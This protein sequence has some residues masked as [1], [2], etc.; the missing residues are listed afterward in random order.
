MALDRYNL[1]IQR[2]KPEQ[3]DKYKKTTPE[4][5]IPC[6]R[7]TKMYLSIGD[8]VTPGGYALASKDWVINA[9]H[10]TEVQG[11]TKGIETS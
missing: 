5:G 1:K 8:G 7:M 2:V 4:A 6:F 10:I 3:E 9:I 11:N